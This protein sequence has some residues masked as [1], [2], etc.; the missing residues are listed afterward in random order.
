[1]SFVHGER[2]S[3]SPLAILR[4]WSVELTS[5]SLLTVTGPPPATVAPPRRRNATAE[6]DF[7]SSLSTRSSGELFFPPPC[8]AGSLTIMGARSPL[9]A[10]PPPA[11]P[12]RA[13]GSVDRTGVPRAALAEAGPTSTGRASVLNAGRAHCACGPSLCHER[14]PSAT[15]QLGRAWFQPR[16]TQIKFYYFL[17]YSIHCKFKILCR[18]HMNSEN[19]ETNFVGKV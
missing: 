2:H 15:V 12:R 6:P 10:P 11:M 8:P 1:V 18:I 7:F 19:Y 17:I 4:L 13:P 5:P 9:F 14:G 3:S 16:G